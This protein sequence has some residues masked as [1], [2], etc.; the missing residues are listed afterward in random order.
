MHKPCTVPANLIPV[1]FE[2]KHLCD[3]H[4]LEKDMSAKSLVPSA[5]V[6]SFRITLRLKYTADNFSAD[7]PKIEHHKKLLERGKQGTLKNSNSN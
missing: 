6:V 5:H 4:V 2:P 3:V 7:G 1:E